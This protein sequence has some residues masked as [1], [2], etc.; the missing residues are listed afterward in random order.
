MPVVSINL[1][2]KA[3]KELDTLRN[4]GGFVGRSETVR[5]A[6]RY[7]AS[8][9]SNTAEKTGV[10]EGLLLLIHDHS[11]KD[12]MDK[13]IHEFKGVIKTQL[14][15]HFDCGKCLNIIILKGDAQ[16]VK[17]FVNS[18]RRIETMENIRFIVTGHYVSGKCA[19]H[20]ANEV[21]GSRI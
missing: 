16:D 7:F 9:I 12:K 15:Q 18:C 21:I 5:A 13:I 6:L 14:H 17:N 20:G 19:G 1:S 10:I 2:E 3:V 4:I 8:E 11:P